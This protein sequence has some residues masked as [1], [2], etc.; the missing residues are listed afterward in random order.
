MPFPNDHGKPMV[1][2]ATVTV[3]GRDLPKLRSGSPRLVL[4][5]AELRRRQQTQYSWDVLASSTLDMKHLLV[6]ARFAARTR[7]PVWITGEPGSGKETVARVIHANSS[8]KDRG[9]AR[10]DCQLL[11]PYVI[12]GMLFGKG[13]LIESPHLGTL[14]LHEPSEL[15][16]D[17]QERVAAIRKVRIICG[18]SRP[19]GED[20]RSGRLLAAYPSELSVIE[21]RVP[22]LRDRRDDLRRI[23]AVWQERDPELR[24]AD[25]A[26]PALQS[27]HW[28]GNLRELGEVLRDARR[29]A[30]KSPITRGHLPRLIQE[31]QLIAD[32]PPSPARHHWTLDEILEATERRLIQLALRKAQGSLTAAAHALGMPRP[33]LARRLEALGIA[34]PEVP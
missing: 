2:L 29:H 26:W 32:H 5:V 28:P 16:R 11:Q 23:V 19:P 1:I 24:V 6:Q 8:R 3:V 27:Y 20:V 10:M 17:L 33:R 12:E 22:P 13:G 4:A 25:D 34:P 31:R 15:P 30:Q 14:Y 9:F 7:A 21:I 18:S